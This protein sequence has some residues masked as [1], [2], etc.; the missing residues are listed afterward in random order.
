MSVNLGVRFVFRYPKFL[1]QSIYFLVFHLIKKSY[2]MKLIINHSKNLL[3][4]RYELPLAIL[5]DQD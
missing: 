3:E 2:A 1:I 5:H 4:V